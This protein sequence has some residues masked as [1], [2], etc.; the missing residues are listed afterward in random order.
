MKCSTVLSATL[1]HSLIRLFTEADELDDTLTCFVRL[2]HALTATLS[3]IDLRY[4]RP[5]NDTSMA[6]GE[7][8]LLVYRSMNV[9]MARLRL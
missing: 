9:V 2:F 6:I 8:S 1:R 7:T 4:L 3:P 5:R